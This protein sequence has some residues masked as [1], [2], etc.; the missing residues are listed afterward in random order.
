MNTDPSIDRSHVVHVAMDLIDLLAEACAGNKP[1]LSD[2]ERLN[3]GESFP[4][5]ICLEIGALVFLAQLENSGLSGLGEPLPSVEAALDSLKSRLSK[6]PDS[7]WKSYAEAEELF[8]RVFKRWSSFPWLRFDSANVAVALDE[9]DDFLQ[10]LVELLWT[11]RHLAPAADAEEPIT[12]RTT[13]S[14]FASMP[15]P[16]KK[17]TKRHAPKHRDLPP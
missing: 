11:C 10:A 16:N 6:D 2:A 12:Y 5:S 8:G 14:L 15:R 7:F 3:E 1:S 17:G 4:R 9:S 13:G